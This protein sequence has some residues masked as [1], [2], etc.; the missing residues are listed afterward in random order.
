[1]M[2]WVLGGAAMLVRTWTWCYTVVLPAE[3]RNCRRAEV[4]SDA[5]EHTHA[6]DALASPFGAAGRLL[7]RVVLGMPDDFLWCGEQLLARRVPL[8]RSVAPL[9][10]AVFGTTLLAIVTAGPTMDP[11]QALR[12]EIVRT[13]WIVIGRDPA[14]VTLVPTASVQLTNVSTRPLGDLQVNALFGASTSDVA[15][16][17]LAFR[18]SIR[19]GGLPSGSVSP[20]TLRPLP[21]EP[22]AARVAGLVDVP[23]ALPP[24]HVRLY[25][26]HRGAWTWLG[27]YPIA[28]QFVHL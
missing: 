19:A 11:S 2:T 1:M 9:A 4:R 21:Q 3:V 8:T 14:R 10:G 12:V 24:S 23:V 16:Y 26:K 15:T 5:W 13:G 7:L 22:I 28:S 6:A 18:W 17:G 27:D 25:V 20:V